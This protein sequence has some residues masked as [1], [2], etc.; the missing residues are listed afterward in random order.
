MGSVEKRK[1]TEVDDARVQKA[2]GQEFSGTW[3]FVD[4]KH[5]L[6]NNVEKWSDLFKLKLIYCHRIAN[7]Q[8][9]QKK[10]PEEVDF[11]DKKREVLIELIDVLDESSAFDYL[12]NEDILQA[13]MDMISKNVYRTFANK[14]KYETWS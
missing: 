3:K 2:V 7:F 6:D 4:C 9:E 13:S 1:F 14:S 8:A 11:R 5:L 10:E 12:L